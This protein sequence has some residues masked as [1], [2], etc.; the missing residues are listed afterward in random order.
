M[1]VIYPDE[2]NFDYNIR[3]QRPDSSAYDL[4]EEKKQI[5]EATEEI[6]KELLAKWRKR[7]AG[8]EIFPQ[9]LANINSES[10]DFLLAFKNTLF[11]DKLAADL[12]LN[13]NQREALPQIV[14]EAVIN[15]DWSGVQGMIAANLGADIQKSK[16]IAELLFANILNEAM[17]LSEKPFV[18][19]A[20]MAVET[21]PSRK[22]ISLPL[23][24]ALKKYPQLGEQVM[25]SNRIQ[26]KVFPDPVRPSIKNWIND[27]Y[28]NLGAEKHGS[29]E[30]GNYLF[31]SRNAKGLTAGERQKLGTVLKAL[32]ENMPLNIDSEKQEVVFSEE[33]S[34]SHDQIIPNQKVQIAGSSDNFAFSSPQRLSSERQNQP[35]NANPKIKGNTVDLRN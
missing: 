22:I 29:I 32:D 11:Y 34:R 5:A 19:R 26:N 24:Q 8:A 35:Q 6:K 33:S 15:K 27:Y 13:S 25:T 4:Q 16:N 18:S 7:Y 21:E 3:S 9:K 20:R 10:V 14:W 12:A 17:K 31:H 30:R 2:E 23:S 28:E 1:T